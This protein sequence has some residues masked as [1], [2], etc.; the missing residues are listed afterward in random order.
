MKGEFTLDMDLV[1]KDVAAAV[2]S[3]FIGYIDMIVMG[4]FD[5]LQDRD[6][7]A[8]YL[9]GAI[10]L[11]NEARSDYR[12]LVDDIVHEAAHAVEENN[13]MTIYSD[14][15]IERE[16]LAKRQVLYFLL[17][18]NGFKEEVDFYDFKNPEYDEQFDI[19]L[20]QEVSYSLLGNLTT[21][22]FNSPYG[23]TSLREYFAN[24][25][26]GYFYTT[27][28][29]SVKMTSPAVAEKIEELIKDD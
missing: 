12:D 3:Q 16:F 17:K 18:E 6:L 24:C 10:Y 7:D 2:P 9:E 14:G 22:L 5:F 29:T 21:G 19:F 8:L 20:Y 15:A 25:F 27:S 26:E 4:E 23:A 13:K 28:P 11:S 1:F